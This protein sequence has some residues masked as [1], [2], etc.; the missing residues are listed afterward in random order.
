LAEIRPIRQVLGGFKRMALRA[1]VL[2]ENIADGVI[3]IQLLGEN[4]YKAL[5]KEKIS[6]IINLRGYVYVRSCVGDY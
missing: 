3:W 4:T 2:G 5:D 1:V 6:S